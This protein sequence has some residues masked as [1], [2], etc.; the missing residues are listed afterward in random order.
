MY[1]VPMTEFNDWRQM[2]DDRGSRNDVETALI[3]FLALPLRR[4]TCDEKRDRLAMNSKK[5]LVQQDSDVHLS[6]RLD[7]WRV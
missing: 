4:N 2:W 3:D 1:D 7:R 5:Q 6:S